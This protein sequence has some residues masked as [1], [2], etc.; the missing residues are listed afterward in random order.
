MFGSLESILL[1]TNPPSPNSLN[2]VLSISYLKYSPRYSDISLLELPTL[3]FIPDLL[4]IHMQINV[5]KSTD[6]TNLSTW[7]V[8]SHQFIIHILFILWKTSKY[9][10]V[11]LKTYMIAQM[12]LE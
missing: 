2:S 5:E 11:P 1:T 7:H 8:A 4:N 10:T 6:L 9:T 12:C 3:W